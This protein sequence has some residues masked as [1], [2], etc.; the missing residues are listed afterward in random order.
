MTWVINTSTEIY[1]SEEVSTWV[2]T[3]ETK[4]L[5]ERVEHVIEQPMLVLDRVTIRHQSGATST[6][7]TTR[8]HRP[9]G[10]TI[11]WEDRP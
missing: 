5:G 8:I 10:V 1:E 4:T 9:E 7:R 3:I 6:V 2:G 11:T